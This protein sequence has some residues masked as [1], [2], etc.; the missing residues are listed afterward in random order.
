M[1]IRRI[2]AS[3]VTEPD[4]DLENSNALP[5]TNELAEL[6]GFAPKTIRR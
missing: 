4:G 2:S 5:S 6:T 1:F 3:Q